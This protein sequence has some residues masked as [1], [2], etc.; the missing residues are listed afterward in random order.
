MTATRLRTCTNFNHISLACQV[1]REG[2]YQPL[3]PGITR[4]YLVRFVPASTPIA[5]SPV[6]GWASWCWALPNAVTINLHDWSA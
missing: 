6:T 2:Q 5:S 3:E 1:V 4:L